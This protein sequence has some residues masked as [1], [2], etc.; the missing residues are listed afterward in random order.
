[1]LAMYLLWG[2]YARSC[3][4]WFRLPKKKK[5]PSLSTI[6]FRALLA[7]GA[8]SSG[9]HKT[10][11]SSIYRTWHF[12]IRSKPSIRP[13]RNSQFH[14]IVKPGCVFCQ[15]HCSSSFAGARAVGWCQLRPSHGR[16]RKVTVYSKAPLT[17]DVSRVLIG[18]RYWVSEICLPVSIIK[19]IF[20]LFSGQYKEG[21]VM[22]KLGG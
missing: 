1:M 3:L 7:Q 13:L 9:L 14:F 11:P 22:Q 15:S 12:W 16:G 21:V 17:R 4:C 5:K 8:L 6:S 2:T 19:I 10:Q 20:A 18:I